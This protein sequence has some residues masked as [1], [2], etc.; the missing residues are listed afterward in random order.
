MERWA[1]FDCYGTLVDWNGGIRAQLARLFGEPSAPALL[2]RY[3]ELEPRV[4]A[5][6]YRSYRAVL[7]LTLERLAAERGLALP[8]A[9][10]GALGDSLPR[11][12]VFPEVP[13]ALE[14]ARARGYRLAILS[15][16]DRDLIEASKRALGV[17]FDETVVAADVGSYKPAHAHWEEFFR[18]TGADPGGHVHVAASLFHDVAPCRELGLRCIWVDRL[19]ERPAAGPARALPDLRGLADALDGLLR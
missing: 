1:T 5:E 16:S 18:R 7:A 10:A 4:Q 13:P 19:G 17:P 2:E 14:E 12:P 11:W 6:G 9:E 15:N 8:P 3:H